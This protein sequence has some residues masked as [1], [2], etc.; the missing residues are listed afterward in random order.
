MPGGQVVETLRGL[1]HASTGPRDARWNAHYAEIPRTVGTAQDKLEAG[2]PQVEF[3]FLK[4]DQERASDDQG[5]APGNE[6]PDPQPK[7]RIINLRD[8]GATRFAGPPPQIRWLVKDSIP[9]GVP[10][11]LAA[12]G[13]IGKS[14]LSLQLCHG[15]ATPPAESAPGAIDLNVQWPIL[16]GSIA[17]HGKAVLI[18]AEDSDAVIH[19]RL[20]VVDPYGRRTNDLMIVAL[21]SAGGPMPLFVQDRNGVRTTADWH[22]IRDQL[23]SIEGLR[24]I[25]IDP[26]AAFAQVLWTW[27]RPRRSS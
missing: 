14:F 18:T 17:E 27:T 15:I 4:G 22:M 11:L 26:L 16:G 23:L 5:Q 24:L 19:R 21:P 20:A 7:A 8:F 12:M 25:A 6:Q 1:M 3:T 13:G 2:R 9:L 10:V